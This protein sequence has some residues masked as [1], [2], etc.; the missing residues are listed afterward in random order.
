MHKYTNILTSKIEGRGLLTMDR[1]SSA[2]ERQQL[3][4]VLQTKNI[5]NRP[6]VI[7]EALAAVRRERKK[8][9]QEAA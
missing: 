9:A 5:K 4:K 3:F 8:N 6:D 7:D 2:I 1:V